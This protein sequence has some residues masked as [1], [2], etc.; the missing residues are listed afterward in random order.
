MKAT[1]ESLNDF[2]VAAVEREV[3]YRQGL[4]AHADIVRVRERVRARTGPHPDPVPLIRAL[5]EG[6]ERE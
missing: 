2:I 4:A 1:Q 6:E 3:R 5:R